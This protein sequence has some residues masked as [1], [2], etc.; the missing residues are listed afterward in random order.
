MVDTLNRVY[1]AVFAPLPKSLTSLLMIAITTTIVLSI[2]VMQVKLK[3]NRKALKFANTKTTVVPAVSIPLLSPFLLSQSKSFAYL[4]MSMQS[5]EDVPQLKPIVFACPT[6]SPQA[7]LQMATDFAQARGF[8]IASLDQTS[9]PCL[10]C[11]GISSR[12]ALQCILWSD[13]IMR[14]VCTA[15]ITMGLVIVIKSQH[16]QALCAWFGTDTVSAERI[17]RSMPTGEVAILLRANVDMVEN[18][19]NLLEFQKLHRDVVPAGLYVAMLRRLCAA[20][21]VSA[22][23][24]H[25]VDKD[26]YVKKVQAWSDL[27]HATV[28]E[29]H[30]GVEYFALFRSGTCVLVSV[31]LYEATDRPCTP[32]FH[33]LHEG[34]PL[35]Y[36]CGHDML[37][38]ADVEGQQALRHVLSDV[39]PILGGSSMA[40]I[41]AVSSSCVGE[42]RFVKVE[43]CRPAQIP[44]GK[45][46]DL[47]WIYRC[48]AAYDL[49]P[50]ADEN[51]LAKAMRAVHDKSLADDIAHLLEGD[52]VPIGLLLKYD[53]AKA[54]CAIPHQQAVNRLRYAALLSQRDLLVPTAAYARYN[55]VTCSSIIRSVDAEGRVVGR[56]RFIRGIVVFPLLVAAVSAYCISRDE[57]VNSAEV[58]S[59]GIAI[60]TISYNF[61]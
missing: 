28:L 60:G 26:Y 8:S 59:T 52:N 16:E 4:S 55:N 36:T 14:E 2:V 51:V 58:L 48:T 45:L 43:L 23:N 29:R 3:P 22:E 27:G 30:T 31:G 11:H 34:L 47:S 49:V 44:G 24:E 1:T 57:N 25:F 15:L 56:K 40:L 10:L 12:R 20:D 7:L 5:C 53:V 32:L 18:D 54:V 21:F 19:D 35:Q 37:G 33:F 13:R 9:R 38:V 41:Y 17:R 61:V 6:T 39:V 50:I 42:F 46:G